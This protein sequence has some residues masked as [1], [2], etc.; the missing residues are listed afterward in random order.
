MG[1]VMW[2]WSRD[3]SAQPSEEVVHTSHQRPSPKR[4]VRTSEKN[5]AGTA[6]EVAVA[7][8]TT[9]E[10]VVKGRLT[11]IVTTSPVQS[12]PCTQM[13]QSLVESFDLVPGLSGCA[14]IIVCDGVREG[15]VCKYRSGQVT[16]EKR[17]DYDGYVERLGD[18]C[19]S[20]SGGFANSV[21][22]RLHERCGFGNAVKAALSR[23]ETKYVMI[24]QH[25]RSFVASFP[26]EGVLAAMDA[27]PAVKYVGLCTSTTLNYAHKIRSRY[28][29]PLQSL[30]VCGLR[31]LPL[32][33]W[34][35]STHIATT[36]HYKE[37]VFGPR[38]LTKGNF[39]EADLGQAQLKDITTRG[40]SA[41]PEY[42]TFLLDTDDRR[43]VAHMDGRGFLNDK[44][45]SELEAQ[46]RRR[47]RETTSS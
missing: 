5:T 24:V 15:S 18:L 31:L 35:D 34:Y 25:D 13:I 6:I 22:I 16:T 2:W 42:G 17:R 1:I 20:G 21:V 11:M 9:M 36:D 47:L 8:P 27:E 19:M 33:Y 7:S 44:M 45:A 29:I 28:Q 26:L 4:R 32:I 14:K 41:H 37:F 30:D 40:M 38:R 39:I 43:I 12:N 10:E 23:V 46:N 3:T